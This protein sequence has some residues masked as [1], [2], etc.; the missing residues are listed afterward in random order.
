V[1]EKSCN[2]HKENYVPKISLSFILAR[3]LRMPNSAYW[4]KTPRSPLKVNR[5][6]GG[7]YQFHLHIRRISQER[8]KRVARNIG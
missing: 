6:F 2:K 3:T 7:T 4:D 8:K 1:I 5:R